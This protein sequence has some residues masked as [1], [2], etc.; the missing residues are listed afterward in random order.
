MNRRGQMVLAV[1]VLLAWM[2]VFAASAYA[3]T[4]DD[5]G[6]LKI[7]MTKAEVTEVM[8]KP[9]SQGDKKGE[10]LCSCFTYKNVGRYKIVNVWFDCSGKL[11]AI[12]K[13]SP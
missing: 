4:E 6:R 7:G 13:A 9:D 11:V 8:G 5:L 3:A 1:G 12:D 10:D 2:A